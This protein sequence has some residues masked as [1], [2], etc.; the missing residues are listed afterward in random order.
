M[1]S[2]LEI[3][4]WESGPKI[5]PATGVKHFLGMLILSLNYSTSRSAREEVLREEVLISG[6]RF[7]ASKQVA[8]RAQTFD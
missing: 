7:T 8:G 6:S 5:G 2:D 4:L 1:I 3:S